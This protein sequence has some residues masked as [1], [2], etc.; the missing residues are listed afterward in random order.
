MDLGL[1][2]VITAIPE[3]QFVKENLLKLDQAESLFTV[4]GRRNNPNATII[5]LMCV[6]VAVLD[7]PIENYRRIL[8]MC[9]ELN[10]I[11][12]E[13]CLSTLNDYFVLIKCK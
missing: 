4:L 2:T 5:L 9:A 8:Q 13:Y 12:S 11:T 6:A 3:T 10:T 7:N 1:I